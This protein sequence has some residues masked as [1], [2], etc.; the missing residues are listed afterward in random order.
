MTWYV[1]LGGRQIN[2]G[3]DKAKAKRAWVR[4]MAQDGEPRDSLL[5]DCIEHYLSKLAPTT[6][7]SR[8]QILDA[9]AR[10]SGGSG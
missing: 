3:R 9:F 10:M 8:K 2:L 5:S 4:L 1:E 6:Y 7:R